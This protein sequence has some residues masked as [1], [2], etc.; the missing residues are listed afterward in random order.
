MI[1]MHAHEA[2]TSPVGPVRPVRRRS[3]LRTCLLGAFAVAVAGLAL[4][5]CASGPAHVQKRHGLG[6]SSLVY[7]EGLRT[8][9]SAHVG[10]TSTTTTGELSARFRTRLLQK[11]REQGMQ[12]RD[13]DG[14]VP[15]DG[16]LV[17]G[18][19]DTVDGGP[20]DGMKVGGQRVHCTIQL[21]NGAETRSE[22]AF[23]LKITGT[24]AIHAIGSEAGAL[25]AAS[26]DAADQV[27]K[28]IRENP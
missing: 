28:F 3:L 17:R 22:P 23:E 8:E 25:Y 18:T 6:G 1:P 19:L 12:T 24:P 16:I 5:G 4:P 27:A 2:R 13:G 26:E 20:T 9:S 15:K 14:G 21:W 7:V 10:R 11:L